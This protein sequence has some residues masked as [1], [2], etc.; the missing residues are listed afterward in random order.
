MLKSIPQVPVTAK[1]KKAPADNSMDSPVPSM[2]L[3]PKNL[4]KE[5]LIVNPLMSV[6]KRKCKG[7]RQTET[8]KK[9]CESNGDKK[10]VRE[11][12]NKQK[13]LLTKVME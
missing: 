3:P 4:K 11:R 6:H 7:D 12:M 8:V 9:Q 13:I 2:L 1:K 5:G 10:T